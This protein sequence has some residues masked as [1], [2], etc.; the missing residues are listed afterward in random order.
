M[1]NYHFDL[2]DTETT[3]QKPVVENVVRNILAWTGMDEVRLEF[4][5][6]EIQEQLQ[7]ESTVGAKKLLSFGSDS[8]VTV[9]VDEQRNPLTRIERAAGYSFERTIF[10]DKEHRIMIT[11]SVV[12]Y[13]VSVTI[14]IRTAS[15]AAA[16]RW[17]N[18]VQ[19]SI[20][21]GAD[22]FVTQAEFYWNIPDEAL[23]ILAELWRVK[24]NSQEPS[25]TL[26][27]YL[28]ANFSDAVTVTSNLRGN[29]RNFA[30]RQKLA[31]IAGWFTDSG[32]EVR[33]GEN[34]VNFESSITYHFTYHSP[35]SV[36]VT[37][38]TSI[39]GLF[40]PEALWPKNL[41]PGWSDEHGSLKNVIVNAG[42]AITGQKV[43]EVVKLPVF[44]PE[45]DKEPPVVAGAPAG[46]VSVAVITFETGRDGFTRPAPL[47]GLDEIEG[48]ELS[49]A[50]LDYVSRS[51]ANDPHCKDSVL[52]IYFLIDNM[53]VD[54]GKVAIDKDLFVW[55]DGNINFQRQHR[56]VI[57]VETV[58]SNLTEEGYLALRESPE[59][60]KEYT[61]AFLPTVADVIKVDPTQ[62]FVPAP[63]LSAIVDAS[64]KIGET[65]MPGTA[66]RALLNS[67]WM[68]LNSSILTYRG[69]S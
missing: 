68:V 29:K 53:V 9:E 15:K 24:Y 8:K 39:N 28:K 37:F 54:G 51:T 18:K 27:D 22:Q 45:C 69:E 1:P 49:E 61:D 3:V 12:Q 25:V 30:M 38:P 58:L 33:K 63:I 65:P 34:T 41:V 60:V 52:K 31:R 50:T 64:V 21:M 23:N 20:D 16:R 7:P 66:A 6:D 13:D 46:T 4:E 47:F 11:P 2:N 10:N 19:R 32:P 14:K 26:L 42:D 40:I 62:E 44:I 57:A 67:R 35:E 43:M 5:N 59:F 56:A 17:Y 36:V 48:L 55:Y